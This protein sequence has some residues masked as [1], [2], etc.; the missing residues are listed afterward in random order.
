MNCSQC[1]K[2]MAAKPTKDGS[3]EKLPRGWKKYAEQPWCDKCWKANFVRRSFLVPLLVPRDDM[4]D[5]FQ[6]VVKTCWEEA[7]ALANWSIRELAKT[8]LVRMPGDEKLGKHP[9][10]NL[11]TVSTPIFREM[12]PSSRAEILSAINRAYTQ[13]RY[14]ALWLRKASLPN[15]RYPYPH[16]VRDEAWKVEGDERGAIFACRIKGQWYRIPL[17]GGR[18]HTRALKAV[19]AC[20][21]P[22]LKGPAVLDRIQ[23]QAPKEARDRDRP[24]GGGQRG[25]FTIGVRFAL[26]VRR[27][28]DKTAS[29]TLYLRTDPNSFWVYHVSDG[30]PKFYNADHLKRWTSEH[31][32][33]LDR[34]SDD[35]KYEK[36]W[37]TK[38]RR[39]FVSSQDPSNDKFHHRMNSF[40]HEATAMITNFAVRNRCCRVI[41]DDSVRTFVDSFRWDLTRTQLASKLEKV[42]ITLECASA[43]LTEGVEK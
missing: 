36:R 1:A 25:Y 10:V 26:W 13:R 7:T 33:K 9:G 42:G 39:R 43:R 5:E 20:R 2:E 30:E 17:L 12:D 29:E 15:Y 16:P 28:A 6:G 37:P 31:R 27:T 34:F 32:N 18:R 4:G 41:Y 11:Y 22:E 23:N 3:G 21:E 19:L 14:D 35:V 24:N 38:L 40:V 8:D